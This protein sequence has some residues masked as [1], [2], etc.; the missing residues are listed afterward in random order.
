NL[1]VG[2]GDQIIV[3]RADAPDVALQ[4]AGIVDILNADS[5]FQAIGIP[6]GSA[7]QAPPDNVVMLP[8]P[9]WQTLFDDH[10]GPGPN[11]A[12][13]LIHL[14]LDRGALPADPKSAYTAALDAGHHL[15]LELA[16]SALLANNLAARL[17]AVRG[18]A[19]YAKVL[20]LFLG[21]PGAILA[22][23][24]TTAIAGA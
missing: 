3:R 17:D 10:L 5:L 8:M 20:F 6:P 12:R 22:A 1:H 16:G 15:E 9:R 7:P 13:M 21:A 24:T 18:D 23:I 2:P 19:L 14:R 4:V 11:G